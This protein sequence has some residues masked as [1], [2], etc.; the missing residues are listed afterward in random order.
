MAGLGLRHKAPIAVIKLARGALANT[1]A[2]R[3]PLV[4][5]AYRKTVRAVWGGRERTV[6]FRGLRLTPPADDHV[7]TAGLIGGFYESIEL[8]LFERLAAASR[9]VIDVGANIGIYACVGAAHLPPGGRLTA[10]EPVPAN[11]ALL[12]RNLAQNGRSDRVTVE[13][14]AVGEAPGATMI[15]LASG[16]GNHSLA[17][18]VTG[19]G[20]GALPVRVTSLSDHL[21]A[22]S[23]VDLLKVDVEG[24]DGYVLRGAAR[25]L[26]EY[27]PT[28]LVEFVPRH[29]RNAGFPPGELLDIV[30]A[31]YRH[32]FAI[33]EPRG[34]LW[35]CTRDQLARH[36]GRRVNLNLVAAANPAHVEVIEDY[37]R[38]A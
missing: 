36:A 32:V 30:F 18:A 22:G 1:P 34:R 28:L 29:L 19:G 11:L 17:A 24:Y 21:G 23:P 9:D 37:R 5:W 26:H 2:Q 4:G 8:D 20:R 14:C 16:S 6:D 31:G 35:R 13:P 33:D 7:F 12:Q 38:S 25:P 3:L 27:R 15:H 10:F